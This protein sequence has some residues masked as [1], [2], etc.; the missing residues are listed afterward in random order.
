MA[1]LRT[2]QRYWSG[3]GNKYLA[4]LES[5]NGVPP[6]GK[7]PSHAPAFMR[8][9]REVTFSEFKKRVDSYD[10][11]FTESMFAGDAYII[12][13]VVP[14][15]K[16]RR[17]RKEL[18][19]WGK[20]VEPSFHKVQDGIPNFHRI[21]TPDIVKKYALKYP[22]H[23]YYFFRHNPDPFGVWP[24]INEFWS[25]TKKWGGFDPDECVRNIPSDGLVDRIVVAH[26][27]AGIGYIER[28][29]DPWGHQRTI[30]SI[31]MTQ[32]DV[33]FRSGGLY[34]ID[35]QGREVTSEGRT[36]VGD[37]VINYP[38]VTHGVNP[39]DMDTL[40]PDWSSMKG[41]WFFGLYTMETDCL[42]HARHTGN[43][44]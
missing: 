28:H 22:R 12:R 4:E 13:G 44:A 39:V 18:H 37:A 38:T 8:E 29:Q 40:N 5:L 32:L 10:R 35:Q 26:Y 7:A 41:R 33:D 36:R 11:E 17:L 14:E 23:D 9:L 19:E 27:P 2:S 16:L 15:D 6:D 43:P 34:F 1:D 42:V 3:G 20:T 24:M 31:Q 25:Y 21:I 30:M